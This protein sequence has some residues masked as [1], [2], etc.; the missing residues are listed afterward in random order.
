MFDQVDTKQ[1]EQNSCGEHRENVDSCKPAE[2]HTYHGT[3]AH[4]SMKI[5][6]NFFHSNS[7][8]IDLELSLPI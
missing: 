1:D 6:A 7:H 3:Y 2:T 4:N 5:I 8:A